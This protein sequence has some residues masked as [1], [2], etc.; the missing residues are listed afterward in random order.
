LYLSPVLEPRAGS[1]HGYDVVNPGRLNPG[2]GNEEDLR[3]LAAALQERGMGLVLDIVPNHMAASVENPWWRSTLQWGL[4]SRYAAF[5][6]IDWRPENRSLWG[7][8]LLPIL[9]RPYPRAL[10]E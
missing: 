10:V 2:L 6:D 1:E 4:R 9:T 7:K 5:F 8:V 3:A